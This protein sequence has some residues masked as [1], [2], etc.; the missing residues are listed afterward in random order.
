MAIPLPNLDARRW[1]DLV[2]E[3]RALIPVSAAGWT[4]HNVHD[5]GITFIELMAWI[6]EASI[7]ECNTVS[8]R[9][10]RKFL[11]LAGF[12][13][14]Y[15]RPAR[16]VLALS[17]AAGGPLAPVPAGTVFIPTGG[18]GAAVR[19]VQEITPSPSVLVS[20]ATFDGVRLTDVTDALR[21]GR[22]VHPFGTNPAASG[23]PET[24]PALYLGFDRPLPIGVPVRLHLYVD[25]GGADER[26]AVVAFANAAAEA[27]GPR[28]WTCVEEDAATVST[29]PTLAH[30]GLQVAWEWRGPSGWE[31][32]DAGAGWT[33]DDTCG[34]TLDGAVLL[35]VPGVIA[36][37]RL[38]EDEADRFYVRCRLVRGRPDAAPILEALCFNAVEVEQTLPAIDRIPLARGAPAP[39]AI[40]TGAVLPMALRLDHHGT[41]QELT[42][43]LTGAPDAL[44]L[45]YAAPTP[46]AEG[47]LESTLVRVASDDGIPGL[48]GSGLPRQS[49]QLKGAPVLPESTK[50]W[51][52]EP[53]SV[54]VA[55]EWTLVDD[56][57]AASPTD[58]FVQLDSETGRLV[59]GDGERGAAPMEG[60]SLVAR[61]DGTEADRGNIRSPGAWRLQD[62]TLN[63]VVLGPGHPALAD[64]TRASPMLTA[65]N[66]VAVDGGS[67][68]EAVGAAA[69]RAA[70]LLWAHERLVDLAQSA[71]V[72]SLDELARADV[73]QR[74]SPARAVTAFDYERLALGAPGTRIRRA[75]AWAGMDPRL[76]CLEAPG[77]VTVVVI[78]ELPLGRP[79]PT[80]GLLEHVRDWLR[81]KRSMGT[82]LHITGPHYVDLDIGVTVRAAFGADDEGVRERVS[83]ALRAFL[84]PLS[85][86]KHGSGWPLGREVYVAELLRVVDEVLGV[87]FVDRLELLADGVDQSCGRVCVPSI[88]LVS[89]RSV[90]VEVTTS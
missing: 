33:S 79:F 83:R 50:V 77:T 1:P 31:A 61:F 29:A 65:T 78:P 74:D 58:R 54:Q 17:I 62:S 69:N 9:H 80:D 23:A 63:R 84:D 38:P 18:A 44:V 59:F 66:P 82:R 56:L 16:G 21:G 70:S 71:G 47:Y 89:V 27:C 13:P 75:R 85:G 24:D 53:A 42:I 51:T 37:S 28:R 52:I 32:I 12:R 3:G 45:D 55:S 49:A 81:P 72:D 36:P 5:P 88:G 6:V 15:P 73:L 87:D 22:V 8:P 67:S 25:G 2:E 10:I 43:G 26:A 46:Q 60:A 14:N 7:F 19:T 41:A 64:L 39:V 34:L 35:N 57:D 20:A 30:H 48:L 68:A 11:S 90:D 86:G 76:G 40:P 4:D